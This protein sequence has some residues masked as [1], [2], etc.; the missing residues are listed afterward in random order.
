MRQQKNLKKLAWI[1]GGISAA[2]LGSPAMSFR[3]SSVGPAGID[4]LRLH[5]PPYNLTGRKIAIGQIDIG[6]PRQFG[7]D[8]ANFFNLPRRAIALTGVFL[9]DT[10][11]KS[12]E[13]SDPQ[14]RFAQEHAENTAA[15]MVSRDKAV[16]GVAPGARLYAAAIGFL[17]RSAQPEECRAAQNLAQQNSGDLRAVNLSFGET[18]RQDPRPNAVLDGNALLTQCLDW[19]ARVHDVLYVVAGNQGRGGIPIPTD[20]YNGITVAYTTRRDG[21]FSKIDFA[22]IGS[23]FSGYRSRLEGIEGNLDNRR[24]IGLVAPG[25]NV[26]LL[27]QDAQVSIASGTSFAAPHVTAT[28][29]LLQ[30][31]GDRQVSTNQPNWSLDARRHEVMKAVMMNAADKIVDAGDGLNQGMTRTIVGAG[32][33]TWLDSD[34][35]KQQEVPL[36]GDMGA[37]QLNAYRAYEQFSAGKWGPEAA[38]PTIGW[39]YGSVSASGQTYQE[40]VIDQPL[41]KGSY[42]AI[43]LAWNRLVELND[44]NNNK[45]YDL[46]ETFS[47]RGL[48]NL[49]VYLMRAEDNDPSKSIWS[50]VSSVDSTEHIFHQIP[51]TGRYKIRVYFRDRINEATQPYALAWWT[52]PA[53]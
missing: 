3:D 18:L 49:D 32:N 28:V 52:V 1:V 24:A 20:N 19:S 15:V 25:S 34:A 31:Y 10:P 21:V 7:L 23:I 41:Q 47:D 4:A 29:A 9:I 5:A 36:D 39:D 13:G 2:L 22:N 45:D 37:G 51:E 30:E 50:S 44:G 35:Y 53:R 12:T 43:T 42:A 48:N 26:S 27:N 40:Y 14:E 38:V 8:K 33:R 6:R 46:G 11:P 16:P 17:N